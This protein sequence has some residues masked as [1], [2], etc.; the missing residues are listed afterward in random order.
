MFDGNQLIHF[1]GT[2]NFVDEIETGQKSNG[3]YERKRRIHAQIKIQ[4]LFNY[5]FKVSRNFTIHFETI[6]ADFQVESVMFVFLI[7][8]FKRGIKMMLSFQYVQT[9]SALSKKLLASDHRLR[10]YKQQKRECLPVNSENR[11]T[12]IP[13]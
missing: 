12:I 6:D 13:V 11:T 7:A 9:E 2:V 3:T 10:E 5:W 4:M 8:Y 1:H